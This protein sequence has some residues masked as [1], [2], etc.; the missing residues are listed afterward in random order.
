MLLS[1]ED[2]V[3]TDL[4]V[5]SHNGL[6]FCV[7]EILHKNTDTFFFLRM[8]FWLCVSGVSTDY[9]QNSKMFVPFRCP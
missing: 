6:E 4:A 7:L 9:T 1:T 8:F 3:P 2:S 5:E